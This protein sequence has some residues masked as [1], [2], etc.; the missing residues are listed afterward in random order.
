MSTAP[1]GRQPP[2]GLNGGY[3]NVAWPPRPVRHEVGCSARASA[4]LNDAFSAASLND[5]FSNVASPLND[6]LSN[7]ASPVNV[8][9]PNVASPLN[10][11]LS[12]LASPVNVAS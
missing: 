11:A 12:N 10:D 4:P 5:A 2:Y 3:L 1:A 9:W 8:A 6:A 7:L